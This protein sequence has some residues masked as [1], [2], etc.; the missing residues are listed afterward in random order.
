[1]KGKKAFSITFRSS[2]QRKKKTNGCSTSKL[3]NSLQ[4]SSRQRHY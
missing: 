2:Y 1:M 3:A 4:E